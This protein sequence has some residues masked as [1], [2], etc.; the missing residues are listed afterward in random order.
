MIWTPV[1]FEKSL[2]IAYSRTHYGTGYYI[3]HLYNNPEKLSRNITSFEIT[4]PPEKEVL[5]LLERSGTD[6][7]PHDIHKITGQAKL[8]RENV[9]IANIDKPMSQIR[10]VKFSVPIEKAIDIE[11]TR[12]VITWDNANHPSVDAPLCL[13][14]ELEHFIT[15]NN[16]N[17]SLKHSP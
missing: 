10:A 17:T 14:L 11:R 6:I 1:P 5:D 16:S 9:L 15:G 4:R 2:R 7:A 8:D 3:Y 13:F 12:L